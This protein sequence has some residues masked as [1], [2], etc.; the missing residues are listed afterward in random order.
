[1]P[2]ALAKKGRKGEPI[3]KK[4]R[5]KQ[6]KRKSTKIIKKNNNCGFCGQ[7]NWSPQH[8][9][10]AKTVQCNNCH[11]IGHLPRKCRSK[12]DNTRKQSVNYLQ[13][14]HSEKEES[15]PEEIQQ[16][17]QINRM[18]SD[19]N[20]KYGIRLKINGKYQNLTIDTGSPVKVMPNSTK[21]YNQ[22][23]IHPLKVRY[24]VV[25]KNETKFLGKIWANSEYNGETT[26]LPKLITQRDDITTLLGINW[27][28]QLPITITKNSL[29]D[30]TN[31]SNS[32]HTKFHKL[33]KTN[34][35][36]RPIPYPYRKT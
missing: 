13:A 28:K 11:T 35:S 12:T 33:V 7:Q 19:K 31:Q 1:M 25:N 27:V 22:K 29:D 14:K 2:P 4:P 9:C 34:Y 17:T 32:I 30:H 24:Q 15:Q 16:T 18:L 23:D 6:N 26:K 36:N 21:F 8:K 10:F 5:N 20:D 3:Q